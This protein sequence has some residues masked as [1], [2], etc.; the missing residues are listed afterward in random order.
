MGNYLCEMKS[1]IIYFKHNQYI[2]KFL[3]KIANFLFYRLFCPACSLCNVTLDKCYHTRNVIEG[4]K[5]NLSHL[6]LKNA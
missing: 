3:S 2:F 5:V 1:I 6:N 4:E